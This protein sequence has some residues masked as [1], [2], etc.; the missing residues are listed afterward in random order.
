VTPWVLLWG[1]TAPANDQSN[2]R[3]ETTR[4]TLK[5]NDEGLPRFLLFFVIAALTTRD[6]VAPSM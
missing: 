1:E 6:D 2:R 4:K 5:G 3:N